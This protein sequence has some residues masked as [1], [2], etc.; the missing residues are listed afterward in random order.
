ML[1]LIVKGI[2]ELLKKL[3]LDGRPNYMGLQILV[4]SKL[5]YEK[6]AAY[7][8]EHW[9]WQLSLHIQYG[10]LLDFDRKK[11]VHSDKIN[12]KSATEY[13]DHVI[14]YL[15]DE[16]AHDAILGPFKSFP[17]EN[18]Q[19]SPFMTRDKSGSTNRG[20]IINVSWPIGHSVNSGVDNDLFGHRL[21]PTL[22]LSR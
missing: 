11:V 15:Q 5:K 20:F 2:I 12:H 16:P 17:I 10:F 7:L 14:T 8:N 18:L 4:G 19:I 13:L 9:D 1:K 6:W 22:P 3:R 21:C